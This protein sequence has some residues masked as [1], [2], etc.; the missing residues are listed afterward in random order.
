MKLKPINSGGRELEVYIIDEPVG[1]II[2][3]PFYAKPEPSGVQQC[4]SSELDLRKFAVTLETVIGE[5]NSV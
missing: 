2:P 4:R 5:T 3:Q 1:K